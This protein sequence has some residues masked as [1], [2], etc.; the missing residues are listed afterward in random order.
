MTS[1]EAPP[2]SSLTPQRLTLQA[3]KQ[4]GLRFGIDYR[5]DGVCTDLAPV[6][7]G[8]VHD[9]SLPQSLHLTLSDLQVE[10]TYWSASRQAVPWFI[11]V[12]LDGHINATLRTKRLSL[13]AGDALCAH[14]NSLHSLTVCQPA[15]PRLRT[16][17]LA[18]L[19][20]EPHALPMPPSEPLLHCWRLPDSLTNALQATIDQPPSAVSLPCLCVPI[21]GKF[22]CGRVFVISNSLFVISHTFA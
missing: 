10:R 18:V 11:S 17:N 9:V 6:A 16:V 21:R 4:L 12:V 3:L 22:L 14:F 19:A 7:Q 2:L 13:T 8:S 20:T 15:Q 5:T 1:S